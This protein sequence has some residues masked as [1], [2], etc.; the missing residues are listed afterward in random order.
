MLVLI[1]LFTVINSELIDNS[2]SA[3]ELLEKFKTT[4]SNLIQDWRPSSGFSKLNINND[5]SSGTV[6]QKNML[7]LTKL[8]IS[9]IISDPDM[10]SNIL[11]SF[12][13]YLYQEDEF[14]LK[15]FSIK[16][17]GG[18]GKIIMLHIQFLPYIN[19]TIKYKKFILVSDFAPG[20]DVIIKRTSKCNIVS[21]KTR[22][23]IIHL[24][25]TITEN[26]I[27]SIM[28]ICANLLYK[29]ETTQQIGY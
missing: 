5:Y 8:W 14:D 9:N 2:K 7:N 16:Y 15:K 29:F 25:P 13:E 21:C 3:I 11:A 17:A 26:H 18:N 1:L 12:E 23:D 19:E 22:D 28:N 20:P 6:K 24:P 10:I 4:K 27:L